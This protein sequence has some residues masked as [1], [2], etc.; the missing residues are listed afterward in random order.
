MRVCGSLQIRAATDLQGEHTWGRSLTCQSKRQVSDLP[1]DRYFLEVNKRQSTVSTRT[2]QHREI[3]ATR[4]HT[5]AEP[6]STCPRRS[7][8][9]HKT[10]DAVALPCRRR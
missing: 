10:T 2:S 9:R 7:C 8:T 4:V 6:R 1:H 5:N 3:R